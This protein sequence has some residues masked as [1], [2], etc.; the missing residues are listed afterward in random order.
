MCRKH[1]RAFELDVLICSRRNLWRD[2]IET[3]SN[4]Y[5]LFMKWMHGNAFEY[6]KWMLQSVVL[7]NILNFYS[8]DFISNNYEINQPSEKNLEK[9]NT[10]V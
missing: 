4:G 8:F 7:V 1:L 6:T 2:V 10:F 5:S 3:Q 9:K